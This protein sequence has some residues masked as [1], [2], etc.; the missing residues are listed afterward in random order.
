MLDG[1]DL[2]LT[3]SKMRVDSATKSRTKKIYLLMERIKQ[4]KGVALQPQCFFPRIHSKA[5]TKGSDVTEPLSS[6]GTLTGGPF[7]RN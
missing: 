3:S 4:D 2:C 6:S 1:A 5:A 7:T